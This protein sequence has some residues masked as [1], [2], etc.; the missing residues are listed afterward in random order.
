M[1][2]AIEELP[3]EYRTAV[4]MSDVEGL[5]YADND[6]RDGLRDVDEY[7]LTVSV[8]R[9]TFVSFLNANRTFFFNAQAFLQHVQGYRS[10]FPGNGPWN[11]L[12]TA[13]VQTGYFQDRLLPS[14]TVVYDHGSSSGAFLPQIR[15]RWTERFSATFGAALFAGRFQE[16]TAPIAPPAPRPPTGAR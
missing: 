14:M 16:T 2:R 3:E 4:V 12:V 8:D 15:Y 11:L 9:P 7:N 6:E 1:I 5:P 13:T 10:S